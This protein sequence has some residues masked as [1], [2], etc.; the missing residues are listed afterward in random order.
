MKKSMIV[1]MGA[2]A[3]LTGVPAASGAMSAGHEAQV[4][5]DPEV[6]LLA[7]ARDGGVSSKGDFRARGAT[8]K[9]LNVE[10]QRAIPGSTFDV[11]LNGQFIGTIT[12]NQ[13]GRGKIELNTQDGEA[14]PAVVAGDTLTVGSMTS[15]F[16]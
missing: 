1:L 12:A 11:A 7:R 6:R 14:V 9:R 16:R 2:A 10:V 15:T 13:F 5:R 3:I 4:Q 8:R